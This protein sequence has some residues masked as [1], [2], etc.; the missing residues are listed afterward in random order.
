[1]GEF[2]DRPFGLRWN[3]CFFIGRLV[4]DPQFF[5]VEGGEGAV[6]SIKTWVPEVGANGQMTDVSYNV[7]IICMN[8]T[9][10]ENT[11]KK[12]VVKDKEVMVGAYYKTWEQ[13]GQPQSGLIMTFVT[14]GSNPFKKVS[15]TSGIPAL[16]TAG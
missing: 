5:P 12:W 6:F 7:P 14:L 11:I 16:P 9:K 13:D 1:M 8:P 2:K 15:A 4:D 10:T 3:M